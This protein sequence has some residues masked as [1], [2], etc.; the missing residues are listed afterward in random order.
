MSKIL[1]VAEKPSAG[2]DIARVLGV[3]NAQNGYM[4]NDEY[5]VTWAL[6]HLIELKD[7]EEADPKYKKWNV[8]DL[9]LPYDNG[10]KV[11][12]GTASQFK[13][14]KRLIQRNDISYLINA[15]DAGREGLLIQSWIYRMCDNTHPVKILWA[16]SLTDDAIKTAMNH[17]H[18]EKEA[19][20][21]NLLREAET[22]ATADQIYGY[23]YTR[24]ITCLYSDSG[25][26]S[27]GRCQTPLLN[28]IYQR[29]MEIEHF[30]SVP[31]WTLEA[32]FNNSFRANEIDDGGK[33]D[34]RR[35]L[36]KE[37]AEN[38][39]QTCSRQGK[40]K[41]CKKEQK[42]QKAPAL[43]NLAEI[44]GT[45]GKKYGLKPDETLEIAQ[46][47][48]ETHKILSYPRTDSRYLSTDL[49][50]EIAEH[51]KSCSFGKF[52]KFI[53]RIDFSAYQMDKTYFNNN[54]V[55]DHHALIPT[56]NSQ[57][58]EIYH[59]LSEQE[60]HFFDEIAASLIAIFYPP[61]QY[62][63]TEILIE[64]SDKTFQA[65][66]SIIQN[67]G[68]KEVMELLGTEDKKK[69]DAE[70]PLPDLAE[71]QILDVTSLE[72]KE[73]KTKPPAKYNPGNIVKLMNKYKIGTS[74]TSANIIQTLEKRKFIVLDNKK[75]YTTTE[76]GRSFIMLV[77]E[78]LKSKNLTIEFE[79]K[80]SQV[81]SGAVTKEQFFQDIT[82]QIR[83]NINLLKKDSPEKKLNRRE[84]IGVCPICGKEIYESGKSWYCSGYAEE[85]KCNFTIWK[86]ICCKSIAASAAKT[87]LASGRTELI[88]GFKSSQ[89][90]EFSAY[91]VL[92]EDYTVG[93]EFP[94]RK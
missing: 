2:K 74:A 25:V 61:Y 28:L 71:G 88:K 43:F 10:L 48:Y 17:L 40:V 62:E 53:E 56:I 57:T 81:N 76:L 36:D 67:P 90:R 26:L 73:G 78:V 60:K 46:K 15:G 87:L 35:Y 39:Y 29:D 64:A 9:P 49:Y 83:E 14:I 37:T 3:T 5:I 20:F 18:D 42:Q 24:A 52:Q 51:V 34:A 32:E 45:M 47:L 31:Y 11:K 13:I 84:S 94:P 59:K 12:S 89:G 1:I 4:E 93:F 8:D 91:L 38:A 54:K 63:S 44:Q 65:D 82:E 58:E 77:P 79:E 16:S 68:Y 75:K 66:G 50:G 6:G 92:K 19:E 33:G 55:S 30:K 80:L 21:V 86:K 7:P 70:Q 23:N 69:S 72:L 27:Y 85:P 41:V 22:R